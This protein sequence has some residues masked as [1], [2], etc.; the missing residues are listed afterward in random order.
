MDSLA[1]SQILGHDKTVKDAD[2]VMRER[3]MEDIT[4]GRITPTEIAHIPLKYLDAANLPGVRSANLLTE[5]KAYK[6]FRYEFGYKFYLKQNEMQWLPH[7]IAMTDDVR[8]WLNKLTDNERTL[9]SNIFP[10]FVQNDVLVQNIYMSQYAKIFKPNELQMTFGAFANME[11]THMAA[12]AYA[13]DSLNLPEGL[14]SDFLEYKEMLDKYNFTAGY[15]MDTLMGI[16]VAMV[17]FGAL[18]EGVQLF[19]SFGIMMNFPRQNKLKG[20]GQVVS[21][22]VRDENLH[23]SFVSMLY[24]TFM[25]EFGHLIDKVKLREAVDYAARTIAAGEVR[26]SEMAFGMGPVPGITLEDHILF[27]QS[28]TDMRLKQ[29]DFDPIF[30]E[31]EHRYDWFDAMTGGIE[32]ANF[33]EQKSSDYSKGA[34]TGT[35][36]DAWDKFD[37]QMENV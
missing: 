3:V 33:F 13:L 28:I 29:F 34:T 7:T 25:N 6:P 23:V 17:V 27:I 2:V 19:G 31:P 20:M 30:G 37:S 5:S 1:L 26:F 21:W 14:Y 8:D 35:W 11:A 18:T 22:S 12:Y 4:V 15:R 9:M 16:A 10:L 24:R 36:G 32:H